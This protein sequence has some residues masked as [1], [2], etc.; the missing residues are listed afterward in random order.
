VEVVDVD[1]TVDGGQA[2]PQ[3][4]EVEAFGSGLDQDPDHI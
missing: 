4:V 3:L 1:N 2:L